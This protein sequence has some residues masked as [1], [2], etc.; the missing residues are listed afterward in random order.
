MPLTFEEFIKAVS[1]ED[2]Q[3][4]HDIYE[5]Y[6]YACK[7]R[8]RHRIKSKKQYEKRK[9]KQQKSILKVDEV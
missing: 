3:I 4:K 9:S 7:E 1:L 5:H 6:V 8:E 2:E